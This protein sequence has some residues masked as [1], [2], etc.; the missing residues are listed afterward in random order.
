MD[1]LKS[2]FFANVSHELRTPL[3]LIMGPITRRLSR[4]DVIGDDRVEF[5]LIERNARL[6]YRHVTDLLDVARIEA[7]KMELHYAEVD[8]DALIRIGASHFESMAH[9]RGIRFQIHASTPLMVQ[10]DQEKVLRVL[11]NLLSTAFKFTPLGGVVAVSL[12]QQG[13]KAEIMVQDNGPGIP[14][15]MR[16]IVFE[17]FRKVEGGA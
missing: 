10:L 3:T 14:E 2:Q 8:L 17:R 9:E 16:E 5:E 6:L 4:Q 11:V 7:R 13:D 12:K 15:S 1:Q